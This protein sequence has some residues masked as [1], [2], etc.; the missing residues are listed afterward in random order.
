VDIKNR[1]ILNDAP[2]DAPL[3]GAGN[4]WG[5]ACSQDGKYVCVAHSGS[6]ELS[7]IDLKRFISVAETSDYYPNIMFFPANRPSLSHNLAALEDFSDK[8]S[9]LGK[10]P[11]ALTIVGNKTITAGYF[12]DFL[13][14]YELALPGSGTKTTRIKKIDLGSEVPKTAERMGEIA[15]YD[16]SLCI[17]SWHSCHSCHPFGR[18][19]G[20]NWD[21]RG[22][23][24]APKNGK[25]LVYSWWT[26]PMNWT[27]SRPNTHESDMAAMTNELFL[28]ADP[29]IALNIDTFL[30]KLKPVP[31]PHLV[32]GS[33][34]ES[35]K[36]GRGI[37]MNNQLDCKD[38]HPAPLF[39]NLK[40]KNAFIMDP[41]DANKEWD[42]PSL[43][44]SW[45]TAPYDHLG[46]FDQMSDLLQLKGMSN[47]SN[48]PQQDFNALLEYIL[49]L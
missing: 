1:K 45:R 39:T 16:A 38:C 15:F 17:Q 36:K 44:E 26:P 18:A 42:T 11:R 19:D 48:L 37:Y 12:D 29:A 47:A 31:S 10:C 24:V 6:N 9:V 21:L 25:S 2:L 20:I 4:P 34:S 40:F 35:G 49:S 14:V 43:I 13:E 27:G 5:I 7:V 22:P 32:K 41:Y 33:L 28:V 30:M 23:L 3:M 46:S 8:I